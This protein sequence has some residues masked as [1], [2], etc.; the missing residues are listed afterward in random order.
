MFKHTCRINISPSQIYVRVYI[1]LGFF[2][3]SSFFILHLGG[4]NLAFLFLNCFSYGEI[5]PSMCHKETQRNQSYIS[6]H[7]SLNTTCS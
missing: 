5:N 7:S 4:K 1:V 3:Y 6:T 2:L